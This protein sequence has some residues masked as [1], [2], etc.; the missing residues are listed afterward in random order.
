VGEKIL[1]TNSKKGKRYV[2]KISNV[3]WAIMNLICPQTFQKTQKWV[4]KQN[5]GRRRELGHVP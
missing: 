2:E 5:N 3:V 4:L 1:K